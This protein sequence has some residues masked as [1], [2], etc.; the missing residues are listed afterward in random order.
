M[1]PSR[2]QSVAHL[3]DL[4]RQG[5]WEELYQR[6]MLWEFPDDALL[7]FQ[8][9]FYRPFAVP[10]MAQILTSTGQFAEATE[11]RS[12]DT[13]LIMYEILHGGLDTPVARQMVALMN[14][15]HRRFSIEPEDFT[16][17]LNAFIVV[18]LRHIDRVGW[19]SPLDIEREA[20][21]RFYQRLGELMGIRTIPGSYREAEAMFDAYEQRMV[22]RSPQGLE[23]GAAVLTVLRQRLPAPLRPIAGRVNAALIGDPLVSAAIG[24][25]PPGAAGT[26]MAAVARANAIRTRRRPAPRQSWFTPGQPAGR[27][28]PHGYHLDQLGHGPAAG[29]PVTSTPS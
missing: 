4:A 29:D 24:L 14:R 28:Y 8:L 9:A 18:P 6:T 22:A 16:Y 5:R 13:G 15:M 20:S 26:L 7:G 11:K 27:V 2:T 23:L 12:Y 1:H 21:C 3:R 25:P 17:I 10:R 19:R